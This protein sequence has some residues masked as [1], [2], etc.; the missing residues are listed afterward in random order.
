M[1]LDD[2]KA[3]WQTLNDRLD[4]EATLKLHTFKEG[5]LDRL[6]KVYV[7]GGL[8]IGLPWWLLWIPFLM[9]LIGHAGVPRRTRALRAGVIGPLLGKSH[10]APTNVRAREINSFMM[11]RSSHTME[12]AWQSA[13][14]AR[15]PSR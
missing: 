6:R 1:E 2:V 13:L 4:A 9:V 5:K 10:A 3:A 15:N 11:R 7:R 12:A 14:T 8:A